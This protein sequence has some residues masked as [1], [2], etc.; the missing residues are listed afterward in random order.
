MVDRIRLNDMAFYGYHGVLPEER[1]LGQRF[2][3]D[4]ELRVD[5]RLAGVADDLTKTVNYA[6]AY[7][8]VRDIVTGPPFQLIEA[9]AERIAERL[10]AAHPSV[11]S[12]AVGVRKPEVPI[13]GSIL[14]SAEVRIERDRGQVAR[15]APN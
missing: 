11:Q 7:A 14:G 15:A 12:V 13:A 8:A 4:V 5:L 9:V 1:T 10:L 6:E 3:V 2:V